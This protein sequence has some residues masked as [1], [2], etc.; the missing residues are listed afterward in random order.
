MD[1]NDFDRLTRVLGDRATRRGVG[2]IVVGVLSGLA[3]RQTRAGQHRGARKRARSGKGRVSAQQ[4]AA[5]AALCKDLFPPGKA[6]GQCVSDGAHSQGPCACDQRCGTET[7]C[8]DRPGFGCCNGR[9]TDRTHNGNCGACGITCPATVDISDDADNIPVALTCCGA[10]GCGIALGEPCDAD[11]EPGE[12]TCCGGLANC[13]AST[14]NP[15]SP[16]GHRC[17][18]PET[19]D[20]HADS[21]CCSG[22]CVAESQ[23]CGQA[24]PPACVGSGLPCE[25]P[26]T[27]GNCCAGTF[28]S[29]I[30]GSQVGVT[31]GSLGTDACCTDTS[32]CFQPSGSCQVCT[33]APGATF[34]TCQVPATC[35]Q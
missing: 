26:G 23:T 28:C 22:V 33:T 16:T 3:V 35:L 25:G 24:A 6:R 12:P 2:S 30:P 17:C 32:Q 9:C 8:C 14:S 31:N 34:G 7:A 10:S 5:C 21:D 4:Q 20:C 13:R 18:R 19:A 27:V 29:C 15:P 1:S 11:P